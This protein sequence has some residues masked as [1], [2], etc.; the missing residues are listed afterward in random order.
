MRAV[1]ELTENW[2]D[3]FGSTMVFSEG[4]AQLLL[5][6]VS[7]VVGKLAGL[8]VEAPTPPSSDREVRVDWRPQPAPSTPP[9][10]RRRSYTLSLRLSG[11]S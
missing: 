4:G 5:D 3:P 6:K 2:L 8:V 11:P 10:S 1:F 9:R 7:D